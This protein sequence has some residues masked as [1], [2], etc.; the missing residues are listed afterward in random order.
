M[1]VR[2]L[3]R[4][5]SGTPRVMLPVIRLR[6]GKGIEDDVKKQL[7]LIKKNKEAEASLASRNEKKRMAKIDRDFAQAEA[8]IKQFTANLPARKGDGRRKRYSRKR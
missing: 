7:S 1:P 3:S 8:F 2:K 4:K 5:L 6:L